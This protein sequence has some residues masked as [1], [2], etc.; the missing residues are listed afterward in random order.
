MWR[1]VDPRDVDRDRPTLSRGSGAGTHEISE[2][3]STSD[4][5]ETLTRDLNL[6]RGPSR[7]RVRVR[8]REYNLRGSEVRTLAAAGTFRVVPAADL[9]EQYRDRGMQDRDLAHLRRQGLIRTQP[10]VVGRTRT[11]LVTLTDRGRDVL[12]EGRRARSAE[13]SQAFYAGISKP[14]ELAHDVRLVPRLRA[15]GPPPRCE[16]RTRASRRPRRGVEA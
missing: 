1:D 8:E 16:G 7:E 5:R 3:G 10:Y 4:L 14:R 6:P 15:S 12:D 2:R 13:P 11:T 9:P